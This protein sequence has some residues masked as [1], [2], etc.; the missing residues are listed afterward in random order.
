MAW[1]LGGVTIH[2][3]ED[4]AGDEPIY[5]EIQVLEATD[6]TL[7]YAGTK[8]EGRTLR[9]HVETAARLATLKAAAKADANVA[10]VSDLG[11]QGNYRIRKLTHR[12][13]HAVNQANPW[14]RC[15]AELTKR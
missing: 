6:T 9:F 3:D 14:W 7:H 13:L 11:A 12:R 5:G 10:L 4:D 1:S 2:T 15:T 8:S